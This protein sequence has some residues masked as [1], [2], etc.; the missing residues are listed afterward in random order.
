[1]RILIAEDDLASRKFLSKLLYGYGQCD[2]TVDGIEAIDAFYIAIQENK[3]YNLILID[4]VMPKLDGMKLLRAIRE[5]EKEEGILDEM[6]AQIIM[7]SALRDIKTIQEA[8]DNGCDEYLEKP[9]DLQKMIRII[10]DLKLP[11]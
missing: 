5:M 1:M 2:L 8:F 6:K 9:I 10:E 4:I 11:E 7:T 3:R